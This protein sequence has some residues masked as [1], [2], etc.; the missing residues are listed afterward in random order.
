MMDPEE[1]ESLVRRLQSSGVKMF[2]CEG[3]NGTLRLRFAPPQG[4]LPVAVA[5]LAAAPAPAMVLPSPGMGYVRLRHPLA[6]DP[7][8]RMGE[9]VS[10]G[11]IVAA[12]QTGEVLVAVEADREGVAGRMLVEDGDLVGYGSPVLEWG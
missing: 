8:V 1:I 11:H 7:F 3:P 4:E 6:G 12:L 2:E 5:T 10:K 9:I